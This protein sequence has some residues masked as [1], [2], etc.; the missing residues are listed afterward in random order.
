MF[1]TWMDANSWLIEMA[2]QR[3]L[4]D[5]WLV[6]PLVFGNQPWFFKGQRSV[7]FDIPESIDL[8]LLSQGLPDH[9]HLPTLRKLDPSIPV[10]ASENAA[11]IVQDLGYTDITVLKHGETT[12]WA[13]QLEVKALPGSP[14]GPF[15]VENALVLT[16]IASHSR[17][18]YEPHGF[19]TAAIE[20][21]E[22]VDVI[23]APIQDLLLPLLGPFIQ[24]SE[25]ALE[26]VKQL[27]PQ[28][29]LP[30]ASGGEVEYSGILDKLLSLG[31]SIQE[32]EQLLQDHDYNTTVLK[33]K[34]GDRI[35]VQLTSS[36]LS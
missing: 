21:L 8:I 27:Q 31:G 19:H 26:V 15:L 20:Q 36:V 6:G 25:F 30:T 11:K 13:D 14:I 16:D 3:I 17:L 32:F 12:T 22:T 9:A 7:S 1:L 35:E 33:P 24:G 4:L 28:Y 10:I 23:I 29:I 2:G 5:P 34:P 18:Y